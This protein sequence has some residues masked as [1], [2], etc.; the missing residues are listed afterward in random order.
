[1]S[2]QVTARIDEDIKQDFERICKNIGLS[3]SSAI[4]MFAHATVKRC[5][6]P[7]DIE[8]DETQDQYDRILSESLKHAQNGNFIKM[9][10]EEF[11]KE[12]VK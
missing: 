11:E 12:Y 8:V 6:L 5:N 2:I 1:M 7:F 10:Y 3:V 9:P 4:N